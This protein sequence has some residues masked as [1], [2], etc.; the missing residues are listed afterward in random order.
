MPSHGLVSD[1]RAHIR[2][3][4]EYGSILF[5]LE[6]I[7]TL[8]LCALLGL[9]IHAAIKAESPMTSSA[10]FEVTNNK[11]WKHNGKHHKGHHDKST[12]D[13]YSNLEL[14]EFGVCT[15]YVGPSRYAEL[16]RLLAQ[17]YTLLFSFLMLTLRPATPLRRRLIVHVDTLLFLAFCLY[18]Y[19]DLWPLL[20]FH[21]SPSDAHNAVTWSRVAIL[22]V[23]AV[24]IPIIRPRTYVPA[25]PSHPAQ[26]QGVIPEQTA[27]WLSFIFYEFMTGLVWKAW[28]TTALPYDQLHPLAD[29]DAAEHLY[30]INMDHLDP[31]KRRANGFKPRHLGWTLI[32]TFRYEVV[33]MSELLEAAWLTADGASLD[34]RHL[35][36]C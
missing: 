14:G 15:F 11:K 24:L 8:C 3:L 17:T 18:S 9:S 20:T 5:T 10:S 29:Y 23:A 4:Q 25:D 30:K 19:R 33:V 34:V 35:R 26:D 13:E 32:W 27:P 12:V 2:S 22:G 31:V 36:V 7:R 1:F 21:L 6:V 28:H 16:Y